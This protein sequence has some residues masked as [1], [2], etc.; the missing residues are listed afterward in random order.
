ML[1][2]SKAVFIYVAPGE[3]RSYSAEAL[4]Q[5]DFALVQTKFESN[6]FI[7]GDEE[8]I[9][10]VHVMRRIV[11]CAL[12]YDVVPCPFTPNNMTTRQTN[13]A[14]RKPF[15]LIP[16][17][18]LLW[19]PGMMI[20]LSSCDKDPEII[21]KTVTDTLVIV[22]TLVVVDTLTIIDVQTIPDTATTFI[23]VRHAETSG[24]GSNPNLSAAGQ[25][26]AETLRR[27]L[28]PLPLSAIY[29]TN[30]NRTMQTAQPIA[31]EKGL[32]V[33]QYDPTDPESLIDLSLNNYPKGIVLIVGHSNTTPDFINAMTGK[34]DA[35]AIGETDYD[36]LFIVQV[37][38]RGDAT[39]L[40]MKY[41]D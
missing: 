6:N 1:L 26:R 39:L 28:S 13:S 24:A 15:F 35:P 4:Q 2:C 20:S 33:L 40:H 41:G 23:L 9:S 8:E 18:F 11:R 7:A 3:R 17:L 19:I 37:S 22:D 27:I 30:F 31:T 10:Q 14:A 25:A 34:Q 16:M 29:S 21:T 38:E 36:N 5:N 32:P 12:H